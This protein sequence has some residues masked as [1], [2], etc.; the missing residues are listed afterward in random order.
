M[1]LEP[2]M[3]LGNYEILSLLGAGGMGQVYKALDRKLER[4][5]AI[6][7]LAG[8]LE[9]QPDKERFLHEARAASALDHPNIGTIYGIDETADGRLYIVMACYEGENLYGRIKRSALPVAQAIDIAAQIA[10]GLAA[11]HAKGIVHR[12]IKPSNIMV[13]AQG[14]KVLDFGLA[15]FA[16]SDHLTRTGT[17]VGTPAYMSP[18]QAMRRAVDHRTDMWSL[19]VVLYEM[20]SGRL[21]FQADS[22]PG[23]LLSIA[24]D[25]PP[26]LENVPAEVETIVYRCLAKDPAERHATCRE[27]IDDLS[28]IRVSGDTMTQTLA[29]PSEEA[30]RKAIAASSRPATAPRASAPG[31]LPA[32]RLRLPIIAGAAVLLAVAAAWLLLPRR[33]AAPANS[34]EKHVLVL[35]FT[36]VGGDPASAAL[37]DGLMETLTSRLSSLEQPGRPLFVVPASEVRRRKLT[38]PTEAR[39]TLGV[40]LVVSG[41]VQRDAGGVRLTVSLIDTSAV[42]PRQVASE[43]IDDP[44]GNFSAA[45]D[46]AVTS[47]ARFLDVDMNPKALGGA[48]GEAGAAPAAYESYLKGLSYLQR[49]DKPGNLDLAIQSMEAAIQTDPRFALAYTRLGEAQWMKNRFQPDPALVEKALSNCKRAGEINAQLAPV[50]VTLGR[51]LAGTGKYDLAVGEFQRALELD[52]NSA[53]AYQQLSRTYEYLGRIPDAE[54][55]LNRAIALRPDFWDVHN[56]LGSFYYRQRNWPKAAAAFRKVIELTPDNA[57]AYSNLGAVLGRM[58]DEAGARRSYEKSIQLSPTYAAYNNLAGNY[59]RAGEWDKAAAAYEKSLKLNDRDYRPWLGLGMAYAAAGERDKAR[60]PFTR[61][62]DLSR[63]EAAR[64]PN[65]ADVKADVAGISARLGRADE[66]QAAIATALALAPSD[67]SVLYEAGMVYIRL[68]QKDRGVEYL[69]Q[70]LAHGY[71]KD[72]MRRD[73]ELRP[74]ANDPAFRILMQ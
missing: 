39:Q 12:D 54:T 53:E 66:A 56:S 5:V 68:G 48:R 46:K 35:P 18:E 7:I 9:E 40:G 33:P 26:P 31:P 63:E 17:T 61:A 51:I 24:T 37:C 60:A 49:Y 72:R 23:T 15:K 36:N 19:G 32:R 3:R 38:D 52:A 69:R 25:P 59:F 14:V 65:R 8:G 21:P 16:A 41:S 2:G 43:V 10:R 57:A 45:Q 13:T 6:K 74:L 22:V 70:S 58:D 50:H 71:P 20:L 62:L 11:A 29:I 1:P 30:R 4:H 42:P 44:A 47:L 55:A 28:R 73:P 27:L 34:R 67:N 64:S